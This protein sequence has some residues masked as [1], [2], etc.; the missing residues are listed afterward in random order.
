MARMS[1]AGIKALIVTGMVLSACASSVLG[2]EVKGPRYM[3]GQVL[4]TWHEQGNRH[5]GVSVVKTDRDVLSVCDELKKDPAVAWAQPNYH[6]HPCQQPNDPDFPDQYAHQ[7]IEMSQAWEIS[8]G[9]RDVVIAILGSGVEIDHP[10]LKDNIWVN[11]GEIPDNRKDDDDN[12]YVDDV[13]GWNF[14][15][16]DSDVTPD[17][18]SSDSSGHE[19]MVAGVIGAVGNNDKGVTGVNWQCSMMVLRLSMDFTSSEIAAA[20]RYAA[21]NGAHVV[22]M[23]FGG[24]ATDWD[25]DLVLKDAVDYAVAHGLLLVASAGN[26]DTGTPHYPAAYPN[27]MAV[28]ST[29]GEDMKTGHSTYGPW[30]D[31]AAPGTDIMTTDVDGQ[32]IA[33]A[34]TSFSAPY[35]AAV[36][37]LVWSHRPTLTAVEIRAIL[38][39]T[40][41][42]VHYDRVDPNQGYLGVGRVNA[43]RALLA[44][45]EAFPL[46]EIVSPLPWQ[47]FSDDLTTLEVTLLV[48]GQSYDLSVRPYGDVV[49]TSVAQGEGGLAS[50]E[51]VIVSRDRLPRGVYEMCLTVTSHGHTHKDLTVFGVGQVQHQAHWP[52]FALSGNA[53]EEVY[54]YSP[55]CA[56]ITG[57]GQNEILQASL[58][59]SDSDYWPMYHVNLWDPNGNNLPGW[60]VSLD[61]YD[62][63]V[64]R[65][66]DIDGDGDNEIV[67]VCYYDAMVFAWHVE[68]GE[69]VQGQW[70]V[71]LSW[72]YS[73]SVSPVLADLDGD[74]DKEILVGMDG[75]ESTSDGLYALQG[76]G[77]FL[78]QRRYIVMGPMAVAD[79]DQDGDVEIA[80]SGYGPGMSNPY[81]YILDHQGQMV[82]RWRGGSG[83]GVVIADVNGDGEGNVVFCT[84][85][86]VQAVSVGGTTLWTT[87]FDTTV[88]TWG[89][90]SVGDL[91]S[92][93]APEIFVSTS[94]TDDAYTYSLLYAF[95][96]TGS[97]LSDQG[98]PKYL[99]GDAWECEPLV[100]DIN[101]N[102]HKELIAGAAGLPYMAWEADGSVAQGF[103][104]LSVA[105]DYWCTPAINDLDQDGDL[106]FMVPGYDYH[107]YVIEMN[108]P[109]EPAA[110]D[111][112]M[113][114]H[115]LQGSASFSKALTWD[116]NVPE[117]VHVGDTLVISLA[118]TVSN[119][120][121]VW[122]SVGNLPQGAV[123]D[124]AANTIVWKPTIDQAFQVFKIQVAM[125]DGIQ[126]IS[127]IFNVTVHM[128]EVL[129]F[130]SMDTNP[131]W[132][133][134]AGWSWGMPTG[135]GSWGGDPMSAFT[136]ASVLGFALNGDY[137]NNLS[138]TLYARTG[139]I[140]CQGYEQ[141]TLSFQRWLGIE[142]PYDQ[143]TLE[144]SND[145][146]LWTVLWTTDQTHISDQ[147]WQHVV[148]ALPDAVA[149]DQATVYVRWGLGPTDDT[150]TYP[151]WNLDDIMVFGD[152]ITE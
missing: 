106:E 22:N 85:D 95:D 21:D 78:W 70:P 57:D 129:Y 91:D 82:K 108:A 3:A 87:P 143:A 134:D 24:S 2:A 142:T 148:Y 9:S 137:A 29:D 136:G 71:A 149:R 27:V 39:N 35:V 17:A 37:A 125:T 65:V 89:A 126:Q 58:N 54:Y 68:S 76:D 104:L 88:D 113:A 8:T 63:P 30:V 152:A 16:A 25:D 67:A 120:L 42:S 33:T 34:G 127:R 124:A 59:F 11:P 12:G 23:S 26:S 20:L 10:D 40:S 105:G 119:S 69:P 4:V 90:M 145:G 50:S 52:K 109:Y 146:V 135:L 46:G 150:V 77:T 32:Y 41:D 83:K 122:F 121:A 36:A 81:S 138:E 79:L 1:S 74:G 43:Y 48:H 107:F 130:E 151:G 19:T 15:Q 93:G 28:S 84:E 49:W 101:H 97:I 123:Y 61:T 103:P 62:A 118:E 45:D 86:S 13:Y 80:L 5:P 96:Q 14:E 139:P 117:N 128:E 102:G 55:L 66:G 75:T 100:A 53:I 56:D 47:T 51:E 110:M 72:Y 112:T 99:M 94:V 141:V 64:C 132:Q 92:D 38:E 6:Y 98:F 131:G 44:A 73:I 144:V 147:T 111:W 31:M 140:D 60:P 133:L 115:D 7:L 114:R 18:Y 116:I